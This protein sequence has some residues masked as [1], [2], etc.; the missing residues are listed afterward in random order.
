MWSRHP[1]TFLFFCLFCSVNILCP[2]MFL[3]VFNG[4]RSIYALCVLRWWQTLDGR[5]FVS[6]AGKITRTSRARQTYAKVYLN[7]NTCQSY[8]RFSGFS[9]RNIANEFPSYFSIPDT[10]LIKGEIKI[11]VTS[12]VCY[13]SRIR[14]KKNIDLLGKKDFFFR[15]KHV[16]SKT[17]HNNAQ[18]LLGC[19]NYDFRQKF[20]TPSYR[21]LDFSVWASQTCCLD[22]K[23]V[24]EKYVF[25]ASR[26][27]ACDYSVYSPQESLRCEF[28]RANAKKKWKKKNISWNG[29]ARRNHHPLK[30]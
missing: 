10:V 3:L 4:Y 22:I 7:V 26:N 2:R 15:K 29:D 25:G 9:K 12:V 21:V 24:Y 19:C 16:H 17:E 11:P 13:E 5:I 18:T 30:F 6:M 1:S 28:S 20:S 8:G 23:K 14:R 27:F